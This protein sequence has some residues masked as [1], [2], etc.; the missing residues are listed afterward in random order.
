M[1]RKACSTIDSR[2]T[3]SL[4]SSGGLF[5]QI[6][7]QPNRC[8]EIIESK[9]INMNGSEESIYLNIRNPIPV[10]IVQD[11]LDMIYYL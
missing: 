3:I 10:F 2:V 1:N 4:T 8:I 11:L 6:K 7:K 5:G 9:M